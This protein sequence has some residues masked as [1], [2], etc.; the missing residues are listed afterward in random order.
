MQKKK[1]KS[2][3]DQGNDALKSVNVHLYFTPTHT[4]HFPDEFPH[5]RVMPVGV[6]IE[7]V[8]LERLLPVF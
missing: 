6:Q 7:G 1:Q 4:W 8:I 5:G 3:K 2:Y